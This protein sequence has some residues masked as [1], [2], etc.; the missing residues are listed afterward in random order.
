MF[1]PTLFKALPMSLGLGLLSVACSSTS[2][3]VNTNAVVTAY[4]MAVQSGEAY[5]LTVLR[6]GDAMTL[7]KGAELAAMTDAHLAFLGTMFDEGF[8]LTSGPLMAPRSDTTLRGFFFMDA[9]DPSAAQAR[10]CEDPATKSGVFTM[11]SMPFKTSFDLRALPPI[12]RGFRIQR[13]NDDVVARPYVIV[14]VP[15]SAA[16]MAIFEQMGDT[17]IFH[18]EVLG[19]SFEGQSLCVMDCMT[20]GDAQTELAK[21]TPMVEDFTFHPWAST[22]SLAELN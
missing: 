18:G 11:E 1:K 17:C 8:L 9:V 3:T 16:A 5:T 15:T 19:G 7:P 21:V 4:D 13:G 2:A 14:T 20:V 6:A 12:E 22:T 10:T